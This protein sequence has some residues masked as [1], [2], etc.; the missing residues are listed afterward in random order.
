MHCIGID[1]YYLKGFGVC[2]LDSA[3]L[4]NR[5]ISENEAYL[6]SDKMIRD[7]YFARLKDE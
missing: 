2:V 4:M 1:D 6:L 5:S 3:A 7:N